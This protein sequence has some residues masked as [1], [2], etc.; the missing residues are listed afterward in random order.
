MN[1][2]K[3]KGVVEVEILGEQRGF[4]FGIASMI[5]LCNLEGK[6]LDE[7]Q[8]SI[9][10]GNIQAFA[11]MMYAAAVQYAKLY[12]KPEPSFEEVANWLDHIEDKTGEIL[13]AAFA[14]PESPNPVA[15]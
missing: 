12:K 1:I 8:K 4:K 7:V 11:N 14:Q 2:D 9:A 10:D 5:M 13:S 15:P 3:I 6:D